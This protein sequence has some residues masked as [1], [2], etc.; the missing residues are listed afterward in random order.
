MS[1]DPETFDLLLST[2]TRFV[3]EQLIPAETEVVETN[4]IPDAIAN[5]MQELGLFGL[6]I[7]EASAT[8]PEQRMLLEVSYCALHTSSRGSCK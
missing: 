5:A 4:R 7:S 6:S 3:D 1:L 2:V 8:D